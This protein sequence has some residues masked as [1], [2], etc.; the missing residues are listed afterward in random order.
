MMGIV[1]TEAVILIN[2]GSEMIL[3]FKARMTLSVG[4]LRS[5]FEGGGVR[6]GSG[7]GRT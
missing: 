4:G 1:G 2:V 6:I 3:S 7:F 5:V